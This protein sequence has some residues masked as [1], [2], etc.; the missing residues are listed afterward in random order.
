MNCC[1]AADFRDDYTHCGHYKS[2]KRRLAAG[3]MNLKDVALGEVDRLIALGSPEPELLEFGRTIKTAQ[4]FRQNIE[5]IVEASRANNRPVVLMT[6][7]FH[8]PADYTRERFEQRRLD[9]GRGVHELPAELW[10]KPEH[11]PPDDCGP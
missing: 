2:L 1:P 11:S 4:P 9:Y 8:L 10:G 3:K 6:F 5:S 7:A